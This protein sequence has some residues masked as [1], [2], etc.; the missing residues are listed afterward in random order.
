M[1]VMVCHNGVTLVDA[2]SLLVYVVW[3]KG[4]VRTVPVRAPS[5]R[6]QDAVCTP[7]GEGGGG[8]QGN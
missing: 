8:V 4:C 5:L 2:F 7:H 6:V 3:T 1:C